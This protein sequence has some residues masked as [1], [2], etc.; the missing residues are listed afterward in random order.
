MLR[1]KL[2]LWVALTGAVAFHA[3]LLLAVTLLLRKRSP[4]PARPTPLR[5]ELRQLESGGEAPSPARKAPPTSVASQEPR[6]RPTR[7]RAPGE[8][9]V[10]AKE[11]PSQPAPWS[12]DWRVGEGI[13]RAGGK[14]SL[15][16]EH[17]EDALGAGNAPQAERLPGPVPEKSPE[18]R[19]AEEKATVARRLEGLV[20]DWKAKERAQ[21]RDDYWQAVEDALGRGF[22]PGWDVLERGGSRKTPSSTL[23]ALVEAWKKQAAAYGKTGNPFAGLPDAPGA[24]KPLGEEVLELAN[25]DRGLGSVSLGRSLPQAG[26]LTMAATASGRIW[27]YRLVASVRVTQREDGSLFSVELVGGSGN[28]AYD[29]LVMRQA[30]SL[31]ALELGPPRQGLQTLWAFETEFSQ[32]PPLPVLGCALDDFIPKDCWHPLQK[33]AHARVRL[34]AIY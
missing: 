23:G 7:E 21:S 24:R 5:V 29:Q 25:E 33:R 31:S 8:A 4:V 14:P 22:D 27:Q 34:L 3:L 1:R 20:S 28:G 18:A 15:R 19:L 9:P 32:L 13:D 30:R 11:A 6:R 12:R 10:T 26:M 17:P 16:L 2:R